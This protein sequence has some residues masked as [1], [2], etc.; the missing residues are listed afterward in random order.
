MV[1]TNVIRRKLINLSEYIEELEPFLQYSYEQYISNYFIKRTGERLIQ[2]IVENMVDINSILISEM[3]HAPS[4]DYYSS[5]EI[6]GELGVIPINFAT[7]LAP[8]TGMRNRL[9]HEYDKIQDK[10]VF[11]SIKKVIEM[12]NMYIEYINKH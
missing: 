7:E 8:C 6:I 9:V 4:K 2:L 3:N 1:Y 11:D 10:I 5:F 12:V